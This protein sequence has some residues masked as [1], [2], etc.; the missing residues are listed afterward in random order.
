M[1]QRFVFFLRQLPPYKLILTGDQQSIAGS[2][3]H[4]TFSSKHNLRYI[5]TTYTDNRFTAGCKLTRHLRRVNT[6]KSTWP[7]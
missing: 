4:S 5:H 6:Y 2:H 1:D 3:Q 7:P